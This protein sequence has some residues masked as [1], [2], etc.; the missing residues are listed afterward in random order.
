M[1]CGVEEVTK[2]VIRPLMIFEFLAYL[3]SPVGC[4]GYFIISISFG[5]NKF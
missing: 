4:M 3:L 5:V 1:G 2:M